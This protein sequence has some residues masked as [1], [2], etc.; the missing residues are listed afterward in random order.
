MY[1]SSS[2]WFCI[3]SHQNCYRPTKFVSKHWYPNDRFSSADKRHGCSLHYFV[4]SY[5]FRKSSTGVM[6]I[7]MEWSGAWRT[8]EV[9][10]LVVKQLMCWQYYSLS[11]VLCVAGGALYSTLYEPN[12]THSVYWHANVRRSLHL[13]PTVHHPLP[14]TCAQHTTIL[15]AQLN[16]LCPKVTT[17]HL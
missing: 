13:K 5:C 3:N 9:V 16:L 11:A 17:D 1:G 8:N 12:T 10:W 7:K 14:F 2:L 4:H 15:S 6:W